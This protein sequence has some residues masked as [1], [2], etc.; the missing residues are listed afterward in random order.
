MFRGINPLYNP[1]GD[2][3]DF[4]GSARRY[5][6]AEVGN[7]EWLK[8][9]IIPFPNMKGLGNPGN[10]KSDKKAKKGLIRRFLAFIY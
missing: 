9:Q 3:V 5:I 8:E 4:D 10:H 1:D 2:N 7:I 6:G